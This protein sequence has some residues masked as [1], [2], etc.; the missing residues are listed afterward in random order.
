[1][2]LAGD[3]DVEDGIDAGEPFADS[4]ANL[5]TADRNIFGIESNG[6]DA[7]TLSDVEGALVVELLGD[8]GETVEAEYFLGADHGVER[9]EAGVVEVDGLFGDTLCH[10]V[11]HHPGGF[12]V[13]LVGVVPADED[14]VDFAGPV[15]ADAGVESADIEGVDCAV[16]VV[17]ARAEDEAD[18]VVRNELDIV[19]HPSFGA[20]H[21]EDVAD[22]D[23]GNRCKGKSQEY[24]EE[25][26]HF[27]GQRYC[28]NLAVREG[29]CRVGWCRSRFGEDAFLQSQTPTEKQTP[30]RLSE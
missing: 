8:D 9:A 3:E 1:M 11:L 17:F 29:S 25:T 5:P 14:V 26:F 23:G 10:E 28:S 30:P 27:G 12:V 20:A 21:N 4:H 7:L 19:V 16:A 24:V 13:G 18:L 15:E 2:G 6:V 22:D